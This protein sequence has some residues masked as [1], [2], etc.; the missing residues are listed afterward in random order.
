MV[1]I[2]RGRWTIDWPVGVPRSIVRPKSIFLDF[3]LRV[4][5]SRCLRTSWICTYCLLW[6]LPSTADVSQVC[7][8]GSFTGSFLH[9]LLFPSRFFLL[10]QQ[11]PLFL[12][13]PYPINL[14]MFCDWSYWPLL[15]YLVSSYFVCFP[16]SSSVLY[17]ETA[18]TIQVDMVGD[19][20]SPWLTIFHICQRVV[21][22]NKWFKKKVE[23]CN[24]P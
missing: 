22:F 2:P 23:S 5:K 13:H 16:A 21:W 8:F 1:A 17:G 6:C 10:V 3:H 14:F 9:H 18:M 20:Y 4:I 19:M 24:I 12:F 15:L 7:I 11:D